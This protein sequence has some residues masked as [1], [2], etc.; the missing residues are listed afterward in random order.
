VAQSQVDT[1][2]PAAGLAP[3]DVGP[4]A[5]WELVDGDP[6]GARR[7]SPAEFRGR[8]PFEPRAPRSLPRGFSFQGLYLRACPHGCAFGELRYSDGLRVLSVYERQ[9]CGWGRGAGRR[10][11]RAGR[12]CGYGPPDRS[13]VLIDQGQAK[14]VRHRRADLR[15]VVTADL[16]ARELLAV[17]RSIP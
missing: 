6:E 17:I 16:T 1:L 12:G 4:P 5:R 2:T 9:P 14:T 15:I 10:G 3:R 7:V 13:P 8:A 11:H